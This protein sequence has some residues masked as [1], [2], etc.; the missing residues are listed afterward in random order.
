MEVGA[1]DGGE[2]G[3]REVSK[4]SSHTGKAYFVSETARVS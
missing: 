2:E 4:I 1:T 3:K